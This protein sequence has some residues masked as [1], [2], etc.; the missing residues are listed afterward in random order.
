MVD[1][2]RAVALGEVSNAGGR[3]VPNTKKVMRIGANHLRKRAGHRA[4]S[5]FVCQRDASDAQTRSS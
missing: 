5:M 2:P 3:E 4:K 1:D